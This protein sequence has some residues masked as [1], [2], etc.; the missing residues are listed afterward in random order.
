MGV[1]APV[2]LHRFSHFVVGVDLGQATDPS[3]VA[4]IERVRGV[5]DSGRR[6]SATPA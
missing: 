2:F 3:A 6:S 5:L 1:T 4:V